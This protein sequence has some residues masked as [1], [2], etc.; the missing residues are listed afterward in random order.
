MMYP[1][2]YISGPAVSILRTQFITKIS[3]WEDIITNNDLSYGTNN[4]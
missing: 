2:R 1:K 3:Q 4:I